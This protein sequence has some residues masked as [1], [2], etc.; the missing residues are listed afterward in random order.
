MIGIGGE[1][2]LLK[3]IKLI[4]RLSAE[5]AALMARD[6]VLIKAQ[7]WV[8]GE[9]GIAVWRFEF[10]L[11]GEASPIVYLP[12]PVRVGFDMQIKLDLPFPIPDPPAVSKHFGDNKIERPTLTSPLDAGAWTR[13]GASG[14]RGA[15]GGHH[16]LSDRQFVL[17]M[18]TPEKAWP[19]IDIVVPFFERVTDGTDHHPLNETSMGGVA[20]R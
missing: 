18:S 7:L 4:A 6:P 15:V 19:D 13:G 8:R 5:I 14:T 2:K 16:I 11:K 3:I 20:L 10:L 17:D 1:F 12:N 9:L